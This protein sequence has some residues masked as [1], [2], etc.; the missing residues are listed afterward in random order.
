MKLTALSYTTRY[1]GITNVSL[2]VSA[3]LYPQTEREERRDDNQ[4]VHESGTGM[5]TFIFITKPRSAT[6]TPLSLCHSALKWTCHFL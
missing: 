4:R 3:S 6:L 5:E 1:G 2:S